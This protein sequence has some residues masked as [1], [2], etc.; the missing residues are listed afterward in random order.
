M[1]VKTTFKTKTR[2][3]LMGQLFE[4]EKEY[5]ISVAN[6]NQQNELNYCIESN[7]LEILKVDYIFADKQEEKEFKQKE[8]EFEEKLKKEDE[9]LKNKIINNSLKLK[10]KIKTK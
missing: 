10:T 4:K 9:E 8:K 3:V 7:F 1:L 5:T 6:D 2:F